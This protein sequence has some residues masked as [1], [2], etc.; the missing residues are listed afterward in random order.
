ML[1]NAYYL[2]TFFQGDLGDNDMVGLSPIT[3]PSKT[4]SPKTKGKGK[5][6]FESERTLQDILEGYENEITCPMY[7]FNATTSGTPNDRFYSVDV[8]MCCR[9]PPLNAGCNGS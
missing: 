6:K 4:A 2:L 1:Q 3:T 5:A 9:L 7:V 8:V